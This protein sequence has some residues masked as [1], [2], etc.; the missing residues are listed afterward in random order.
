[1]YTAPICSP[2]T[3][4][5]VSLGQ[6]AFAAHTGVQP[7]V[8]TNWCGPNEA[9]AI[10]VRLDVG[11][12]IATATQPVSS[13]PACT[14]EQQPLDAH[15][16]ALLS[17][18]AAHSQCRS[19]TAGGNRRLAGLWA[20]RTVIEEAATRTAKTATERA[21]QREATAEHRAKAEERYRGQLAA[22][23]VA[24]LDFAPEHAALA[25]TIAE[26]A[27]ERAAA[28]GSGRVG[29]TRTLAVEERAALA[30]RAYIRPT[31]ATATRSTKTLSTKPPSTRG[32]TTSTCTGASRPRP[33]KASTISSGA[34]ADHERALTTML[35]RRKT[36]P[37]LAGLRAGVSP[38][39][40]DVQ[41]CLE[42][43]VSESRASPER[44]AAE[45]TPRPW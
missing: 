17:R 28:V 29:R 38:S 35:R 26:N 13:P 12:V 10:T 15:P 40:S 3:C 21:N 44:R 18:A 33:R 16:A 32:G 6:G 34:T 43:I 37:R 41:T 25:E 14:S 9:F 22:A 5:T 39:R 42:G 19:G 20:P 2:N 24:F 36:E 45:A 7:F 23:I 27:S 8:W 31:S 11:G 4:T 1:M 30:A